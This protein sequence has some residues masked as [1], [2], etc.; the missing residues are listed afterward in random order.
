MSDEKIDFRSAYDVMTA[1]DKS[2][3]ILSLVL[4][5]TGNGEAVKRCLGNVIR[6]ANETLLRRTE[7]IIYL[8]RLDEL[9]P[10]IDEIRAYCTELEN[11]FGIASVLMS[12][13]FHGTAEESALAGARHATGHY[14]WMFGE[15]RVFLPEGMAKLEQFV[16]ANV[17]DCAYFN[18]KWADRE[19]KSFGQYS[20]F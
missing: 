13:E 1:P 2:A 12:P 4:P 9:K 18:S 11:V 17:G 3:P 15:Q 8:N 19:G 20:T 10:D 7:L 14:L 16:L 6:Q 5:T